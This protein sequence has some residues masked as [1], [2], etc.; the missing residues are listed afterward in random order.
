MDLKELLGEELAGKAAAATDDL[1]K[2]IIARLTTEKLMRGDPKDYVPKADFNEKNELVKSLKEQAAK[3]AEDLKSLEAKASGNA[4]LQAEI[5][6]MRTANEQQKKEADAA[7][8]KAKKESALQVALLDNGVLDPQ[9]RTVLSKNFDIDTLE[10]DE[11]GK[12]KGFDTLLKPIKDNPAFKGMFG[13]ARM[14][15][16]SH[17]T[18]DAVRPDEIQTRLEAAQK[19]GNLREVVALRRQLSEAQKEKG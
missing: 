14:V 4:T 9:A 2:Q 10:L 6:T 1:T 5:A 7:I 18:G 13:T 3:H 17:E 19:A 15:G 11:T 16:Q 12:P 8:L